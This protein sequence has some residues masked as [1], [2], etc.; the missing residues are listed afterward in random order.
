METC[1]LHSNV[2]WSRNAA[3][4]KHYGTPRISGYGNSGV[5]SD[6]GPFLDSVPPMASNMDWSRPDLT[7]HSAICMPEASSAEDPSASPVIS[8]VLVF[9]DSV[10][11]R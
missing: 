9:R 10:Y 4:R 5:S 6:L 8:E 2:P 1:P 11:V 7:C 3:F